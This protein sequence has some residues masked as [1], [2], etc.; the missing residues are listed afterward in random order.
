MENVD[1][2]VFNSRYLLFNVIKWLYTKEFAK[3]KYSLIVIVYYH[4]H[5]DY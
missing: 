3:L 1:T 2:L 5:F 4:A